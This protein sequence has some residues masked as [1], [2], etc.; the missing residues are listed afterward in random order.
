M[1]NVNIHTEA[2][3]FLRLL[4][5]GNCSTK[6]KSRL[7][8]IELANNVKDQ[9]IQLYMDFSDM[10]FGINKFSNPNSDISSLE[11]IL[12][13]I[14]SKAC[15]CEHDLVDYIWLIVHGSKDDIT[16]KKLEHH[17]NS[18]IHNIH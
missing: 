8:R 10:Y 3:E 14:K 1:S 11:Q 13:D 16:K 4:A 15:Q 6:C 5:F 12:T 18:I 17:Y 9:V 7:T 2:T